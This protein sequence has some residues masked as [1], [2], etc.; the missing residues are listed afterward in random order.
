MEPAKPCTAG[1]VRTAWLQR[2]RWRISREHLPI[3][4]GREA[5]KAGGSWTHLTRKRE[6]AK[7]SVSTDGRRQ[8]LG[9]D[10]L[11]APWLGRGVASRRHGHGRARPGYR[12]GLADD[13]RRQFRSTRPDDGCTD[14]DASRERA[15]LLAR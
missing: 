14:H 2:L 15:P 5:S 13:T 7:P 6:S 8:W 4:S 9:A 10:N 11:V 12:P 1:A 3:R